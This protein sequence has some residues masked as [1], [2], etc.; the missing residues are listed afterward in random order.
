MSCGAGTTGGVGAVGG[1]AFAPRVIA[2][3][4]ATN[5]EKESDGN[6]EMPLQSNMA[7][8][9]TPVAIVYT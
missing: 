9:T 2:A 5:A 7:A 3:G 1:A 4:E 6:G 8:A